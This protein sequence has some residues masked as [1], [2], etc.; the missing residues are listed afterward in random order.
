MPISRLSEDARLDHIRSAVDQGTQE[1]IEETDEEID[2]LEERIAEIKQTLRRKEEDKSERKNNLRSDKNQLE[3]YERVQS[4]A[5]SGELEEI[6][7]TIETNEELQEDLSEASQKQD[8]LQR[9][10]RSK[11]KEKGQ[12]KRYRESE[13]NGIIAEAVNDFVCPA[14]S[15]HVD[16]DLAKDRLSRS[17]CPFCAVEDRSDE[18]KAD[19]DDKISRSEEELEVIE[20]ELEE[21]N[22]ELERVNEQIEEIREEQPALSDVDGRIERIIR[23]ND[24]DFSAIVEE[25]EEELERYQSSIDEIEEV[26]SDREGEIEELED[27][28]E[29][30]EERLEEA[31]DE[32]EVMREESINAEIEEFSEEWQEI[33]EKMAGEIG[34]EIQMMQDGGIEIPGSGGPRKYDRAGDL[35]DAEITFMN[36]SFAVAYNRFVRESNTTKWATIV[37]DEPFSNLDAEGKEN[38]LEFIDSCDEQ[39]I[40]TSSDES[41]LTEFPKIGQLTR[42]QIQ[43]SLGRYAQ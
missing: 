12:W 10:R 13:R 11:R 40:C 5:E 8:S 29:S 4:L 6:I 20:E 43:A 35:S 41:L 26:I 30:S 1:E 36:I 37:C 31:K 18:I 42:Q 22:S 17:R 39:F 9:K 14:C 33:F 23:N 3:K 32:V 27:E 34:L 16:T 7:E 21:I 38:L 24:Y 19:I 2:Q 15:G 28:L 25:T